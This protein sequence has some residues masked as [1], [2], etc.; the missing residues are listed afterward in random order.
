MKKDTLRTCIFYDPEAERERDEEYGCMGQW[1]AGNS[2]SPYC[3]R[4]RAN[5]SYWQRADKRRPGAMRRYRHKL[6]CRHARLN[7]W[8]GVTHHDIENKV[9]NIKNARKR[10]HG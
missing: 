10:K 9:I 2:E 4:C 7:E 1:Q 3:P 6:A 5:L 8:S